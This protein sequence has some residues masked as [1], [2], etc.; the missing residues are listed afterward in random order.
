[1][2]KNIYKEKLGVFRMIKNGKKRLFLWV[3]GLIIIAGAAGYGYTNYQ[4]NKIKQV[5]I[6]KTNEEL[7][8]SESAANMDKEIT[9]I[10]LFGVNTTEDET[11]TSDSIIIL[12]IDKRHNKI[13]L[14][15]V[16]RDTY[17]PN[18]VGNRVTKINY[19]YVYGGPTLALKTLNGNFNLNI[20]DYV[21]VNFEGFES[22]IDSIGGI[23]ME[24][25]S[26][27]LPSMRSVG[28]YSAGTYHL[29]GKQALEYSRIRYQGNG[30]YERTE[31]QRNVLTAVFTKIKSRGIAELPALVS[32]IIPY[33]ETSLT[34]ADI[35][36]LGTTV[37][38]SNMDIDKVRFPVDGYY[39]EELINKIFYIAVDIEAT[40]DQI[41]KF[42]YED[43]KPVAK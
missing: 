8:I 35:I 40:A 14:S 27:E 11:N 13:K 30:D 3:L 16:M 10:A 25:K 19:A 33:T 7:N 31:R 39:H 5:E 18:L 15:S 29:N 32:N 6:P 26:Y 20:K 42:I 4:L 9:N 38:T 24:I 1:M 37:L 41:H 34:N 43:Q 36:N 22:I 12:S 2:S 17:M 28:I 21:T 23:E